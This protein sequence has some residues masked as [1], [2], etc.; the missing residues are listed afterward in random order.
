MTAEAA[1]G[2][3]TPTAITAA[4]TGTIP[5]RNSQ[6]PRKTR[7]MTPTPPRKARYRKWSHHDKHR[8]RH[9]AKFRVSG[10]V[11]GSVIRTWT[12]YQTNVA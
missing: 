4:T 9:T 1:S 3:I 10:L 12:S 7:P 5:K 2:T 11:G 8:A 6:C